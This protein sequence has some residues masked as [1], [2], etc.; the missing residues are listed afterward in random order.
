MKSEAIVTRVLLLFVLAVFAVQPV[1]AQNG[2]REQD[3][4]E[5][6]TDDFF[7]RPLE[8]LLKQEEYERMIRE[9]DSLLTTRR[10]IDFPPRDI[11]GPSAYPGVSDVYPRLPLV[12]RHNRVDGVFIGLRTQ[13]MQWQPQSARIMK[14]YGSLGYGFRSR[15][16]QYSI[17]AE[18]LFGFG[19]NFKMGVIY[20]NILHTEDMWRTAP[21]EN[22]LS[23]L[24]M[25]YDFLE[26]YEVEGVKP[27]AIFR[28]GPYLEH[29]FSFFSEE[30]RSAENNTRFAFFGKNRHINPQIAE[31][32]LQSFKWNTNFHTGGFVLSDR[33]AVSGDIQAETGDAGWLDSDFRFNRYE[34]E[35]KSDFLIDPSA[36]L[37]F[38][39]RGGTS[40]GTLPPQREFALGGIGTMRGR[41]YKRFRGSDMLLI[42]SELHLGDHVRSTRPYTDG[43]EVDWSEFLAYLIFD[44]G[45]VN[46][47]FQ[48]QEVF[49]EGFNDFSV[50]DF[51]TDIGIG[52][53]LPLSR[54]SALRFELAWPTDNFEAGPAFWVRFNPTF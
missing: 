39:V 15:N 3:P 19:Q 26:Y 9:T 8:D 5:Q 42:N 2:D 34:L 50:S 49:M 51:K 28:T 1:I 6:E 7:D 48:E 29:T 33:I 38:R 12:F 16:W 20:R 53:S 35:V 17:G 27:Y 14:I 24:F 32:Q 23:S 31:G 52:M 36:I 45:W 40:V 37:R 44:A 30:H 18:R 43:F 41:A 10:R 21:I 22:T 11:A 46:Q 4:E 54:M 13:P 47:Q 25:G